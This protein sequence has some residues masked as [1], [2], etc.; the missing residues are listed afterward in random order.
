MDIHRDT[1]SSIIED[2]AIHARDVTDLLITDVGL[3]Q[4]EVD[5]MWSFVKKNKKK[6]S[7]EMIDQINMAIVGFT[8]PSNLTQ[9]ST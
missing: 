8:Q 4:I 5:E 1:V 2:L 9:N 6:L 7:K 3:T